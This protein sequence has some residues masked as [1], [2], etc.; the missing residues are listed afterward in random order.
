MIRIRLLFALAVALVAL[1][2]TAAYAGGET[3]LTYQWS[4]GDFAPPANPGDPCVYT[5]HNLDFEGQVE[6]KWDNTVG[7]ADTVYRQSGICNVDPIVNQTIRNMT[8]DQWTDWHVSIANGYIAVGSASVY[9][10]QVPTPAWVVE[11]QGLYDGDTKA[12]GFLAHVVSGMDTQ[13]DPF[14]EQLLVNFVYEPNVLGMQVTINQYPT[15][16]WPIPEPGSMAAL[17]AGLAGL[18][19]GAIRR[20]VR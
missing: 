5:K 14:L 3:P 8:P 10:V 6:Y 12:T 1:S 4:E 11:Y 7:N 13:V 2:A 15:K 16:D 17:L 9:N 18:G 19:L 20:R